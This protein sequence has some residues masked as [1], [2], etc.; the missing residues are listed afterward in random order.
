MLDNRRVISGPLVLSDSS[1][2]V[3]KQGFMCSVD[4]IRQVWRREKVSA[5]GPCCYMST[6]PHRLQEFVRYI[7]CISVVLGKLITLKVFWPIMWG[8][9]ELSLIC[10]DHV[11]SFLYMCLPQYSLIASEAI[12]ETSETT[13]AVCSSRALATVSEDIG[14]YLEAV[15]I[16]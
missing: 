10:L 1:M 11:L 16:C 4:Y 13:I 6:A 15:Q 8:R 3:R 7:V 12:L 14:M 5:F 2:T 9:H